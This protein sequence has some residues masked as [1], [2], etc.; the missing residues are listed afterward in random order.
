MYCFNCGEKIKNETQKFCIYC[1]VS[2]NKFARNDQARRKSHPPTPLPAP[3]VKFTSRPIYPVKQ[4]ITNRQASHHQTPTMIRQIFGKNSKQC[5]MLSLGSFLL[6]VISLIISLHVYLII[7][8]SLYYEYD[9]FEMW[10]FFNYFSSLEILMFPMPNTFLEDGARMLAH[11]SG[12]L[13]LVFGAAGLILGF[14]ARRIRRRAVYNEFD[15]TLVKIA[16]VFSILGIILNIIGAGLGGLFSY[17]P[18]FITRSNLFNI[19]FF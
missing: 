19:Q 15:N 6:A 7:D 10:Y 17:I 5:F 11:V 2:L 14:F 18:F 13:L 16:G 1:G 9:L 4:K 3:S 8:S 12:A